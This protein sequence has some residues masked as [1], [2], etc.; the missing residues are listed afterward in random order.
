ME[1][2]K[3]GEPQLSFAR[4]SLPAGGENFYGN[5]GVRYG[6]IP[7]SSKKKNWNKFVFIPPFLILVREEMD[8]GKFGSI[9]AV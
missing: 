2:R 3:Y 8:F 6:Y 7:T 1:V 4:K 5:E 9:N